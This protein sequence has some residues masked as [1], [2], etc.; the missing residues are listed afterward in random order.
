MN[1]KVIRFTASWC[2]PCKLF[3]PTFD[4]V[5]AQTSGVYFETIDVDSGNNLIL[6]YNIRN[7]PTTVIIENN[8]NIRKQAGIMS[9]DQLKK[10][11][12]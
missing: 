3:A 4:K 6:E 1:K 5:A 9:E 10:F 7:V 2:M 8:G 11:I 12:G